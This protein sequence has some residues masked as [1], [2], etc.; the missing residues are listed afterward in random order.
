MA[1]LQ[2]IATKAGV[3]KVTVSKVINNYESVSTATREKVHRALRE[4]NVLASDL[5]RSKDSSM[6]I[7]MLMPLGDMTGNRFSMGILAGAEEKALEKDYFILIGNTVSMEREMKVTAKMLQRDVDGLILLSV[8]GELDGRHLEELI[9]KRVPVVLVD[10]TFKDFPAHV[11]R[12][13]NFAAAIK[14]ID[15]LVELGHCR[16]ACITLNPVR[17]THADRVKGYRIG[18]MNSE[19]KGQDLYYKIVGNGVNSYEAT[20]SLLSMDSPP[21]A[22]FVAQPSMLMNVFKAVQDQGLRVPEDISIVAF[23]EQYA[24]LPEEYRGFFTSINQSAKLIGSIAIEILCQQMNDTSLEY[25]EIILPGVMNV[26]NS[27]GPAPSV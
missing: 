7:G 16:I 22:L 1:N 8:S 21:T 9:N 2:D 23:D 26:R 14:L 25:Q 3:S 11:V 24:I 6:M 12:G 18:L 13:D 20:R 17:S 10:Q 5:K 15:H 27:T 19:I 4:M